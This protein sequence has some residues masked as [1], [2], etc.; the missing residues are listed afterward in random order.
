MY[1]YEPDYPGIDNNNYG[2]S[3][4]LNNTREPHKKYD[5]ACARF[6]RNQL[7]MIK[8]KK[9]T[10]GAIYGIYAVMILVFNLDLPYNELY[11]SGMIMV[12]LM[13]LVAFNYGKH[14]Y[15]RELDFVYFCRE[16]AKWEQTDE[17]RKFNEKRY[18][19][20]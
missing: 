15:I 3:F 7:D 19:N 18:A 16:E 8:T 10:L 11:G 6:K 12:F 1:H 9:R 4:S 13:N 2:P 5:E 14:C 17:G 20:I